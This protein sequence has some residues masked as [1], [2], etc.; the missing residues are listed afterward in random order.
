MSGAEN[1]RETLLRLLEAGPRSQRE[2]VVE[3]VRAGDP[4]SRGL[5]RKLLR[6]LMEEERV[7][8]LGKDNT[9]RG[10]PLTYA[11]VTP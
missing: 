4:A 2:M 5:V 6:A 9:R 7:V 1:S 8:C 11:L 3:L 10:N